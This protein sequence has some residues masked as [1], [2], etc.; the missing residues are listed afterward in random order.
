MNS[1]YAFDGTRYGLDEVYVIGFYYPGYDTPIDSIFK[2]SFLGNFYEFPFIHNGLNFLTAE[3]AYQSEKF[4]DNKTMFQN[5]NG[6]D[7]FKLSRTLSNATIF[8]PDQAWDLMYNV[9]TSKFANPPLSNMLQNTRNSFLVEHNI[10]KGRDTRWSDDFDGTGLNWMGLLLMI[11]RDKARLPT[12]QYWTHWIKNHINIHNGKLT[13]NSYWNNVVG[14]ATRTLRLL[15]VK[16]SVSSSSLNPRS[17]SSSSSL[18]SRPKV[19]KSSKSSSSSLNS[20]VPI[21]PLHTRVP[22]LPI[23]NI[24]KPNIEARICPVSPPYFKKCSRPGC[25]SQNYSDQYREYPCCSQLCAIASTSRICSRPG[26]ISQKYRDQYTE[27]PCCS[28][29]C[30]IASTSRICSRPDCISQKYRDQYKEY[31]CCSQLCA[32]ASI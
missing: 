30:A 6:N 4:P 32:I 26:C 31:P 24:F 14:D 9:L 25:I 23:I 11:I 10:V 13:N 15:L 8:N 2:C 20:T 27:F 28:L 17:S 5:L 22:V 21:L 19:S 3:S 12:N 16:P 18:N 7:A 1:P 29:L